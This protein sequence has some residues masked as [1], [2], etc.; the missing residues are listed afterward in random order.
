MNQAQKQE[1]L[2]QSK[3]HF[4][5]DMLLKGTYGSDEDK[6]FKGCSVGCHL[7]HIK[8]KLSA[9]SISNL[10]NKHAIVAKHYGYPEWLAL[11]QDQVFEGLPNGPHG[12]NAKWHVEL[13]ETLAKLPTRYDWQA[14]LHRVH[15]AILRVSYKTAG[16]AQAAVQ[17][18]IDLHERAGRGEKV[19]DDL[20]SA[21]WSAAERAARSA[22]ESAARSAARS[23]AWSAAW[24]AAES[25][26]ESAARSA[27]WSAAERAARSAAR[28]AAYQEI[29]DSV[30]LALTQSE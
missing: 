26:A 3:A 1:F 25:A 22:T 6:A 12:E 20:W 4:A 9:N 13:A 11:L 2:K 5:A 24:S 29:R 23:A 10:N 17:Q 27:A 19:S 15:V 14:A 30:L 16:S 8:P 18:V 28:S 21:A 7:H